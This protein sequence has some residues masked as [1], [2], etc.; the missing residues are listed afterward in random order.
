VSGFAL[1][2][3]RDR[4][5]VGPAVLDTM[6]AALAHRGPDGRHMRLHAHIGLG[7]QH[8]WTTP[9]EAG[10]KQ[11]L[12]D[13]GD[14]FDILFDGR[15]DNRPE[16]LS[17]L[18]LDDPGGRRLSDAALPLRAHA[19][20]GEGCFERLLG[21]FALAVFD[22][23]QE[24]VTC[25][26]DPLGNRTLFYYID[27]LVLVVASEEAAV[28]AHP[29]VSDRLDETTLA[30][31]FA[32]RLPASG[33]TFFAEVQEL[34]PAHVITVGPDTM[35]TS[36]YWDVDPG[37]QLRFRTDD[38]YAD[39]FRDLLRESVRCRLRATSPVGV[40]MSGGLD[41]PSVAALAARE[42]AAG[43]E[44]SRL[45]TFS[46]VFDE[47]PDCDERSFMA[48]MIDRH[49]LDATQIPGDGEWPL[50]D[51]DSW[52]RNPN[53]PDGNPYRRLKQRVYRSAREH[54]TRV[55]LTGIF[56]D[57]M[58][59]GAEHY[60]ADLLVERRLLEAARQLLATMRCAGP[61]SPF[62]RSAVRRALGQALGRQARRALPER[63]NPVW[64]TPYAGSLLPEVEPWPPSA[65]GARRPNQHESLL[66]LYAAR[67][68]T[69]EI[70]FANQ[71]GI[72][73]RHPY[74]DR[75]L[76]EFMLSIPAHQLY[77]NGRFKHVLRQAMHG[78]LPEPLRNREQPT[79]L[80]PLFMRGLAEREP[81]TAHTLLNAPNALWQRYV[82]PEWIKRAMPSADE[83]PGGQAEM[84][85]VWHCVAAE[86]WYRGAASRP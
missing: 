35:R 81:A 25:A 54:G 47:L 80:G 7:H 3:Y 52:P 58:Y 42:L 67:S 40:M 4:T 29:T 84:V 41:S 39:R 10:E 37:R 69:G 38:E 23:Q 8:F 75:R 76:V 79:S 44:P 72:E 34:L 22:R 46:Y 77:R 30:H 49:D 5:P 61:R 19:R 12:S 64:L 73:L 68:A 6:L 48:H 24:R 66:G 14:R 31:F 21:S 74:R 78:I 27:P 26:R 55:L 62:I 71:A 70:T 1:I 16:L 63:L 33:A 65:D 45:R 86:M 17:T 11:P 20:W 57:H 56:G 59:S 18:D 53:M 50:R 43:P 28:A 13:P 82:R 36:R 51:A 9:E 85:V 60:L 83:R 32:L 15:L 2:Y